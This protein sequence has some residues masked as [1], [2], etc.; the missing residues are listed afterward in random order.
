M[1]NNLKILLLL[2]VIFLMSSCITQQSLR[3]SRLAAEWDVERYETHEPNGQK[4]EIENAGTIVLRRDGTGMQ[5]FSSSLIQKSKT[6]DSQFRWENTARTVSIKA[7]QYEPRKVWI[8]VKSSPGGQ[9]WYS[10][11]SEGGVQILELKR[12]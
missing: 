7:S 3:S 8:I 2:S 11:D 10:T 6:D 12:K 5:T 1:K 4:V 9:L